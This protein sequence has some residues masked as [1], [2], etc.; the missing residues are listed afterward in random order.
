MEA[1]VPFIAELKKYEKFAVN[2]I[3]KHEYKEA[4]FYA[5]RIVEHATDS[6]RH[7]AMKIEAQ[8]AASP[9]DM[10]DAISFTTKL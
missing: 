3:S 1:K 5:G 10:T 8:I 6:M 7:Y 2:A 9:T 4:I